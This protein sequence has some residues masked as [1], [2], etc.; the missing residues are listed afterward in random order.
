MTIGEKFKTVRKAK[1]LTLAEVANLLKYKSTGH[2]SQIE[3]DEKPPPDSLVDHFKIVFSIN[4]HWWETG[5]GEIFQERREKP[6]TA[7]EHHPQWA[8][9]ERVDAATEFLIQWAKEEAKGKTLGEI[10][11][12][13]AEMREAMRRKKSPVK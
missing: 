5:E 7:N 3:R 1:K 12:I 8:G 11:E 10:A 4:E 2:L 6:P 13:I 9:N